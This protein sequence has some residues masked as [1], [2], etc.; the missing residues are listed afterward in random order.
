MA[1]IAPALLAANFARLLD[2]L[3]V[4][5][6]AGATM[7]HVD[8]CDG[9]FAPGITVGQP[10]IERL[11][12]ATDLALDVHLLVERPERYVAEFAAAGADRIAIH[13]EATPQLHRALDLV[14]AAGAK[15]GIALNPATPVGWV[16]DVLESVDF[17]TILSADPGAGRNPFLP[18][19]V[20]KLQAVAQFRS[21]RRW[22]LALQVEGDV[23]FDNLAE[24]IRAGADILV[25]GS[26]I[27]DNQD[28]VG[29]LTDLMNLASAVSETSR[30]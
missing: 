23:G 7:I 13:A 12:R 22:P 6:T 30:V 8:V 15:A 20:G 18:Q 17:L 11:R 3:D 29:R 24:F 1:V 10:V 21:E 2:A 4:A 26:A 19:S 14:R 5:K 28:P 16:A 9:H 25:V 27:F